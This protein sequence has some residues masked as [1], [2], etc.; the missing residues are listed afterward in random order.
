MAKE[1]IIGSVNEATL[2]EAQEYALEVS[3]QEK[4]TTQEWDWVQDRISE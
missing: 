2:L 4:L 1:K 3:I